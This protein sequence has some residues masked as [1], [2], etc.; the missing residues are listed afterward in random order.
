MQNAI[1][2]TAAAFIWLGMCDQPTF[3]T[4]TINHLYLWLH[5]QQ[6]VQLELIM[7]ASSKI[8]EEAQ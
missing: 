6:Q 5:D 4:F 2:Q 3:D 8:K 1:A 7:V